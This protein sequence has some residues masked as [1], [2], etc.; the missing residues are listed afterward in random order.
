MQIDILIVGAGPVGLF[1]ANECARRGLRY[2]LIEERSAQSEHSKALAVFP[3]TLE[4]FDMAGLVSPF[5]ERANRVTS[6]AVITHGQSLAH[7]RFAPEESPYPF[8]AMVPQDVTERLLLEALRRKGGDVEYRTAFVSA[9]EQD[10]QVD[11]VVNRDGAHENI[12]ARYV[13]GCDG[14][15]SAVRHLL[16]IPFEGGEYQQAFLLADVETNPD[17]PADEMQLCPSELGPLAIFPMSPI[18]RRIVATID[19]QE[20]TAPSLE[21]VQ[22]ILAERAPIG[23]EARSLRW[24][25]YFRIHHRVAIDLRKGRMF[26][27]GDAAHIHSPFGGQ[28]MN[29][30]LQDVWNL[31]WKLDLTLRGHGS[32]KLL[33]SYSAERRPVIKQVIE[34]TDLL[35][36]VMGTPNKF[37]Q[38][39]RNTVIPMV[40]HLSPFQHA[41]VQRL[42]ELGIAY[43]TSPLVEGP[44]KRYL[45]DSMRGGSGIGSRFL[46]LIHE[47]ENIPLKT[48]AQ[49]L[50]AMFDD[51]AEFRSSQKPGITLVRPDGYVA[52][53]TRSHDT[54][55]SLDAVRSLLERHIAN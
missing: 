46:L 10:S 39:I 37:V 14:A 29:T 52:Y 48:A 50:C 16:K 27:A 8:I 15:H 25:S 47:D 43:G 41:F 34:T 7:M 26:I 4:V 54:V 44:G 1:L 5:L 55:A 17:V 24:S 33:E 38:A 30:G 28:G 2:R 19:R 32:D 45:E 18:R 36:K 40:S 42:S 51:V 23:L 11:V 9:A 20:G 12:T 3:R 35:T 21:L 13:I 22:R 53:E 31:V 6:V 49:Q